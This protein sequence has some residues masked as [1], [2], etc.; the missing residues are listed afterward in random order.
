VSSYLIDIGVVYR[1]NIIS[2]RVVRSSS[3]KMVWSVWEVCKLAP[4]K[5]IDLA[6]EILTHIVIFIQHFMKEDPS[7]M[8]K[9][10]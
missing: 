9:S 4:G 5:S 8:L 6:L 1:S 10:S 3:L 7:R 2:D